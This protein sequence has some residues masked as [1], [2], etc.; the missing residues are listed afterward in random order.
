MTAHAFIKH[1]SPGRLRIG[2]PDHINDREFFQELQKDFSDKYPTLIIRANPIT[3]SILLTQEEEG[4]NFKNILDKAE[5]DGLIDMIDRE[6]GQRPTV[7]LTIGFRHM[8]RFVDRLIRDFTRGR[9]DI[10]VFAGVSLIG[11]GFLQ[12]RSGKVLPAAVTLFLNAFAFM[13]TNKPK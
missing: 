9:A 6:L 8:I 3:G 2:F 5:E 12:L 4:G 7:D 1:E 11:L 13:E 10:K